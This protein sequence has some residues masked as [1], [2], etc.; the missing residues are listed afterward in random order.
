M[1]LYIED[2]SGLGSEN[3]RKQ[4]SWKICQYTEVRPVTSDYGLSAAR[5]VIKLSVE[6]RRGCGLNTWTTAADSACQ[7][8]SDTTIHEPKRQ[9]LAG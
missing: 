2:T 5:L 6:T 4:S 8:F 7:P 9:P 1:W 3:V